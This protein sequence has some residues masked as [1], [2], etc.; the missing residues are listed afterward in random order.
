MAGRIIRCVFFEDGRLVEKKRILSK[1]V[2]KID[3][4][5]IA[6]I[7]QGRDNPMKRYRRVYKKYFGWF[8]VPI[9]CELIKIILPEGITEIDKF[10]F[11]GYDCLKEIV[12]PNSVIKIDNYAFLGCTSLRKVIIS[13]RVKIPQQLNILEIS[14]YAFWECPKF[15]IIFSKDI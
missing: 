7:M 6:Q 3:N 5:T 9:S 4:R 13:A 1:G 12:I 15:S 14:Q 11:A 8:D 2:T 10:T